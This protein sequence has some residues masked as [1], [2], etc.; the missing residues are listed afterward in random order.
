MVYTVKVDSDTV[1]DVTD[2]ATTGEQTFATA[3]WAEVGF[4]G[5][6]IRLNRSVKFKISVAETSVLTRPD[7]DAVR[8]YY[9]SSSDLKCFDTFYPGLTLK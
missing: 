2:E 3:S 9:I 4:D 1:N 8:S 7:L 6:F 5:F